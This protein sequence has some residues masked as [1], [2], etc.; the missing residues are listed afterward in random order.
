LGKQTNL[1][2]LF[3]EYRVPEKIRDDVADRLVCLGCGAQLSRWADVGVKH[4]FEEAHDRRI[5]EARK[6]YERSLLEFQ[7][8][9]RDYP[10]LGASHPVGRKILR[11]IGSFPSQALIGPTW[12]RAR[13]VVSG[14]R[15][16]TA[17]MFPPDPSR[18]SIPAGR[19]NHAGQAYW[20]L[21]STPEAAAAEAAGPSE[22]LAWVQS[23]E[24]E[25][26]VKVLD[27]RAWEAEDDRFWDEEGNPREVPLSAVA[28][29]FTDQLVEWVAREA[30]QKAAYHVPRFVADAAR[31]AGFE[32][33]L[34]RSPRHF[35]D[36]LVL[37][38]RSLR[39]RPVRKPKLVTIPGHLIRIQEGGL[40]FIGGFPMLPEP[41]LLLMTA[42]EGEPDGANNEMGSQGNQSQHGV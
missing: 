41:P 9:L 30:P 12:F 28:L 6:H 15:V 38:D 29:I 18:V 17:N 4:D 32:G 33:I 24:I 27:V 1:E 42:Q 34:F 7:A 31:K 25:A 14:R 40:F 26:T 21:A 13:Q 2:N 35:D 39:L 11:E 8:Y 37:F 19:Y 10:Y 16:T 3:D 20:Y 5:N 36:N 23:F 22:E